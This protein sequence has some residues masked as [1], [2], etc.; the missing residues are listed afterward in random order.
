MPKR[1]YN[2]YNKPENKEVGD[3]Y[4]NN[5]HPF[6]MESKGRGKKE[7]VFS[8]TPQSEAV[9]EIVR[10]ERIRALKV[11][12]KLLG[13]FGSNAEFYQEFKKAIGL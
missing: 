12:K 4:M 7:M 11:L 8:N 3:I 5:Q 2:Y 9:E 6:A 10:A 1:D 13:N